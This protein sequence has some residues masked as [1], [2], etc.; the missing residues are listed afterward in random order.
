MSLVTIEFSWCGNSSLRAH[1]H[2]RSCVL[3]RWRRGAIGFLIWVA[4]VL[5][6]LSSGRIWSDVQPMAE[7]LAKCELSSL[8]G[9][10]E[11]KVR[12]ERRRQVT[13]S[14]FCHRRR[15]KT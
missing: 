2:F 13:Q 10:S 5:T 6:P 4:L 8:T 3:A 7:Q 1:A 15:R 11:E 12:K 14:C 9:S